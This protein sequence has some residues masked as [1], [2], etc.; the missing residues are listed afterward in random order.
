MSKYIEQQPFSCGLSL[1]RN[2]KYEYAYINENGEEVVPFGTYSW[3]DPQFVCGYAR[4]LIQS[5]F[6]TKKW[7]V[8]DTQGNVVIPI[9]YDNIWT[10]KEGYL[11]CI[12][13]LQEGK[14]VTLSLFKLKKKFILNGLTYVRS[15]SIEEFK[16]TF[17]VSKI[18]V[19]KDIATNE[20]FMEYGLS[21]G[22]VALNGTPN[23]P[24]ISIV[25]NCIGD[26]FTML[27]ESEDLGKKAFHKKTTAGNT[28]TPK[29]VRK[30]TGRYHKTS[31]ADYEN[32]KM[33]E[34]WSD[35]YGDIAAY[36]DGWD[37]DD[38]DSGLYDAYEGDNDEYNN[39]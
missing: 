34:D 12:K 15:F 16:N 22:A 4:V 3:C 11:N 21:I 32:E 10:L 13:A 26:M 6:D 37:S 33:N 36:N 39:R 31:F 28:A 9:V 14:E 2:E 7:G 18:H 17:H 24:I 29:Q 25:V 38:V 20:L 27:H 1:V 23:E 35:P 5:A 8:I 30:E 19:K